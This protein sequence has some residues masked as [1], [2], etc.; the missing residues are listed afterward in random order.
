VAD[1]LSFTVM[2][3]IFIEPK[4][5]WHWSRDRLTQWQLEQFNRQ[6]E[7]ILPQNQFYR[8]KL[9]QAGLLSQPLLGSLDD[10]ALWPMTTKAELSQSSQQS[11]TGI[12]SHHT[13]SAENYSRLHRT[14]GTRGDP[15]LILD[16]ASDWS[17]WSATWQHVLESAGVSAA[18]RVFLAFSFG[19]FIG[20]WS[21]HQSCVDR[22]AMVIPGGGL[23]TL[24]RLEFMRQSAA[25]V[26]CCT[27]TYALH[28]AEV[29][30]K[31]GFP[32]ADLQVE[33]LIVAGEAGGSV[34]SVRQRI[35]DNWQAD[36]IDHAGATEI[37]PWGFGWSDRCGLH[38]IESNF[39]VELLPLAANGLFDST[40]P[41]GSVGAV[42]ELVLTSL[43]RYGAPVIRYRTGDIVRLQ[44]TGPDSQRCG[45]AWLPEGVIGRVDD[46][47]TIRGV[48]V[49]PSSI[50]SL[51]RQLPEIGEYQVTLSRQGQLDQ[52]SL[53]IEG[54]PAVAQQLEQL[55][56][57]KLGLRVSVDVAEGDSLPRS[58]AKSRRWVDR[59]D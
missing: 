31:Q 56:L 15:I 25:T 57:L 19:P 39:I 34:P 32:L 33:R 48:N 42:G 49:F 4:V 27:P 40:S 53:Q 44:R 18:D 14:S 9:E 23:S 35:V 30:Q 59:R 7:Q 54:S 24:A 8:A 3:E 21:A 13:F 2:H 55:I 51:V 5:C 1:P 41:G 45:F 50:D 22:G 26:V 46:M 10:L 47:I 20:F 38:L 28:L 12:S 16:T 6:I 52:L 43:G 11:G 58:E 36:V 37:G 29:A 17:W